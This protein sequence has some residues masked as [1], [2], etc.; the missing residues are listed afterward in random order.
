MEDKHNNGMLQSLLLGGGSGGGGSGL[1]PVTPA[2]N[3]KLLGVDG[4]EWKAVDAPAGMEEI[5]Y[6]ALK[7][8]RDGGNLVPGRA[9][10][11]TDYVTAINGTYDLSAIGA[12]G[13]VHYA[14]SAGHP[15]DIIV[16]ADDE[17]HLNEGARA[18]LHSGDT[19]FANSKLG[20]W[21]IKYAL[22]NDPTR[23]AWADSTNGKGVVWWM[24]DEFN[25]EAGFDFKNVQVL[26]YALAMAD[27]SATPNRLCYDASTQPNRY[28]SVY[29][30][31]TALQS[32]MN[33][34]SY[35]NPFHNGCDFAVGYNIL[36]T[37]QFPTVDATYLATFNADWYYTF[38]SLNS[39]AHRDMSLNGDGKLLCYE[40]EIALCGDSLASTL[41]LPVIPLGLN[42]SCWQDNDQVNSHSAVGNK[43]A[44][45][46]FL[47]IFGANCDMNRLG[48]GSYANIFGVGCS[49]N[50]FEVICYSNTFGAGCNNN[51]FGEDCRGNTFGDDCND[52]TL[53]ADC[54]S[55]TF[56]ADCDSNTFGA[57]CSSNTFGADCSSNTFGDGCNSNTFGNGCNSNTFGNGC[58]SNIFGN[59]CNSNIFGNGCN[60]N[61]FGDYCNSNTFGNGC[62]SNIFGNGCNSNT[63][64][65]YCTRNTFGADCN[66]NTFGGSCHD[67]TFRGDCNN[68]SC[69][70]PPGGYVVENVHVFTTFPTSLMS[71]ELYDAAI[72]GKNYPI[73]I[74]LDS[75]GRLVASWWNGLTREGMYKAN[76]SDS[77]HTL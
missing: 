19:Y 51:T 76:A 36:G 70:I 8:L 39:G 66:S 4:G 53:G 5:T 18:A 25:N 62:N 60:S 41:S 10:R 21:E 3:G 56:G 22:D 27:Q 35:V 23:F 69:T 1:P 65:D 33:G 9:Y 7:A 63:F 64:G 77:W 61:T 6:S 75:Q 26:C 49:H 54:D 28:G 59:G 73:D 43:L 31:F 67:N 45:N 34:G 52:N 74:G 14:K 12:S 15:F 24:R 46:S 13:Y 58:N 20:A 42:A 72:A 50:T 44:L 17:N 40:N 57:D 30:V 47:N 32:Y 55:N 37:V 38:D 11:I 2:D 71:C 68:L 29:A 48:S 16:V